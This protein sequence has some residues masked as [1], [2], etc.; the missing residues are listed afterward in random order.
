MKAVFTAAPFLRDSRE[1]K[2]SRRKAEREVHGAKVVPIPFC[3]F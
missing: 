1:R 3:G 2:G